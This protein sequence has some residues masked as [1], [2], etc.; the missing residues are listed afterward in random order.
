VRPHYWRSHSW[1]SQWLLLDVYR[2][3]VWWLEVPKMQYNL[4]NLPFKHRLWAKPR[5]RGPTVDR[6][7]FAHETVH[8]YPYT[9]TGARAQARVVW[10][11]LKSTII[12]CLNDTSVQCKQNRS[13]TST[14]SQHSPRSTRL[15]QPQRL[16]L[17]AGPPNNSNYWSPLINLQQNEMRRLNAH[18]ATVSGRKGKDL[19]RKG[20]RCRQA[21]VPE[22]SVRNEYPDNAP[23]Q[24]G[25]GY[26]TSHGIYVFRMDLGT[27]SDY[28]PTQHWQILQPRYSVYCAVRSGYLKIILSQFAAESVVRLPCEFCGAESSTGTDFCPSSLPRVFCCQYHSAQARYLSSS[29]QEETNKTRETLENNAI[30]EIG[31]HCIET[32]LSLRL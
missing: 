10:T 16:A 1:C 20:Q 11:N 5:A 21:G 28:I 22:E 7:T 31:Q 6:F 27:N 3:P 26:S 9:K 14:K 18:T 30:S 29:T 32:T 23:V 4:A 25:T 13:Q 2:L 12:H 8:I 19:R 24:F 17:T 15:Y